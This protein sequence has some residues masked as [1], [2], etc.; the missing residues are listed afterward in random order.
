MILPLFLHKTGPQTGNSVDHPPHH[1]H[2]WK[3]LELTEILAPTLG[4][5]EVE[6]Q[7]PDFFQRA[8]T[9]VGLFRWTVSYVQVY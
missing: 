4:G 3:A 9:E 8:R 1:I 2:H 7:A 6:N 5:F